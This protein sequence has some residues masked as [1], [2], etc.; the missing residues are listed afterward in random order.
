MNSNIS[1]RMTQVSFFYS[2]I[3]SLILCQGQT[4][5]FIICEYLVNDERQS[6]HYECHQIGSQAFAIEWRYSECCA[7]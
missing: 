7:S 5:H 2:L 6:K 4:F 1:S 3:L